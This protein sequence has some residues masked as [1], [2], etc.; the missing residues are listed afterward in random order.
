MLNEYT[1]FLAKNSLTT[2]MCMSISYYMYVS[3]LAYQKISCKWAYGNS[4]TSQWY[5]NTELYRI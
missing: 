2:D 1:Y 5:G 4:I 3:F